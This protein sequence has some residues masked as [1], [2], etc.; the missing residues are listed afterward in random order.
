M[1]DPI[2]V[3]KDHLWPVLGLV[4]FESLEELEDGW[5]FP[6]GQ[7]PW[8]IWQVQFY[9]LE[10]LIDHVFLVIVVDDQGRAGNFIEML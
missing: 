9:I 8:H 3:N 7:K 2:S 5:Q 10:I 1:D 4:L 6:K